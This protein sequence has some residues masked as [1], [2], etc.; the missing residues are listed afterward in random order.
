MDKVIKMEITKVSSR[1]SDQ[2]SY[3]LR[4]VEQSYIQEAFGN[5]ERSF[6]SSQGFE[7][8]SANSPAYSSTTKLYVRGNSSLGNNNTL[9]ISKTLVRKVMHAVREYNSHLIIPDLLPMPKLYLNEPFI[10]E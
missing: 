9:S 2:P 8:R 7:L 1:Y 4:I 3:R 5:P 6:I 10:I